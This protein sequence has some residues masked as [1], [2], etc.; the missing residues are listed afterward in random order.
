M[1]TTTS[2]SAKSDFVMLRPRCPEMSRPRSAITVMA[3]PEGGWFSSAQIP[4]DRATNCLSSPSLCVFALNNACAIGERQMLAVHTKRTAP[5]IVR[6]AKDIRVLAGAQSVHRLVSP[7]RFRARVNLAF[8]RQGDR[9]QKGLDADGLRRRVRSVPGNRGTR[10]NNYPHA[11]AMAAGVAQ[12]FSR[13]DFLA[14]FW[15]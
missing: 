10:R 3:W 14:K 15:L 6:R 11:R 2:A 1:V 4:A 7:V 5:I 8:H 9:I 13:G 12:V